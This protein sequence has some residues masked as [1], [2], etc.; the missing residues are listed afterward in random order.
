MIFCSGILTAAFDRIAAA[1]Y[2][3]LAAFFHCAAVRFHHTAAARC[4]GAARGRILSARSTAS[5]C[6]IS[7]LRFADLLCGVFRIYS[8]ALL[9]EIKNFLKRLGPI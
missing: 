9:I 6:L 5:A 4:I 1:R 2:G 3:I 8:R 7:L